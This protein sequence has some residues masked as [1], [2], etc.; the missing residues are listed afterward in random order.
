[1]IDAE[2]GNE[3]LANLAIKSAREVAGSKKEDGISY[4]LDIKQQGIR[5]PLMDDYE[6]EILRITSTSTLEEAWQKERKN[7]V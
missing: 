3:N 7:I 4:L 1:M 6:K 5:T 2:Y